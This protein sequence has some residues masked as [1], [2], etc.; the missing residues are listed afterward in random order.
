MPS[1]ALVTVL[2]LTSSFLFALG[3]QFQSIGLTEVNSNRGTAISIT[4][5]AFMYWLLAPLNLK[6]SN[7]FEPSLL[8]FILVGIFRPSLSANLAVAATRFLG[9]TLSTTLSSTTPV[10]GS[11]LGILWLGESYSWELAI[12]TTGIIGSIVFLSSG[13]RS[14][15]SN[16]PLWALA[17]PLGAA[18]IRSLAHVLTKIGMMDIPDPYFAGLI[19]FSVSALI[20]NT[21]LTYSSTNQSINWKLKGTYWFALAGV[22]M[23]IAIISLNTAL[24]NGPIT[25]VIP[26]V[27]IS[28]IFTM[29]LSIL[30][31]KK[32]TISV[33][34][35]IALLTVIPSVLLITLAH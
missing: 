24:L 19:S 21:I 22:T 17:L 25:L 10:F 7:F 11:I 2:A 1:D 18:L 32:E 4:S 9:P 14:L 6:L 27:A 20:T 12:G 29:L 26:I 30:V 33:K 15:K 28:P 23:G 31:F 8:I 3:V 5:S 13:K 35:Y 34:S 16:W